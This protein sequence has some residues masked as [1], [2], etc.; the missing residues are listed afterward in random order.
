MD[1]KERMYNLVAINE[2]T[3]EKA[4][5]TSKPATHSE[6]CIMKSKFSEHPLRRI[7]LEETK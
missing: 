6:C 4:I 3:N 7:Q 2:R 5:L 1:T